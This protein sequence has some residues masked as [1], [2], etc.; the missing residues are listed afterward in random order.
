MRLCWLRSTLCSSKKCSFFAVGSL[1]KKKCSPEGL[2]ARCPLLVAGSIAWTLAEA[3]EQAWHNLLF[4]NQ[5]VPS[6]SSLSPHCPEKWQN[7]HKLCAQMAQMKAE[8]LKVTTP[9]A[10]WHLFFISSKSMTLHHEAEQKVIYSKP[11]DNQR[12]AGSWHFVVSDTFS[13]PKNMLSEMD[14][15]L[16]RAA[17]TSWMFC[18]EILGGNTNK[19]RLS[20]LLQSL[21]PDSQGGSEAS[22]GA[23]GTWVSNSPAIYCDNYIL[24][25]LTLV[26]S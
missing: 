20:S 14:T 24:L 21:C 4:S 5:T 22:C 23:W 13:S 9:F 26:A 3:S 1:H 25:D 18:T 6:P 2:N 7:L 10:T 12:W 15:L 16:N 19:L 11:L 17:L 8:M